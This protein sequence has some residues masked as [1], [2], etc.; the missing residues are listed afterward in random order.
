[1]NTPRRPFPAFPLRLSHL[2]VLALLGGCA[3]QDFVKKE[4]EPYGDR[5][6]SMESWFS[7][8]NNGMDTQAKR[9]LEVE[10]RLAGLEKKNATLAARQEGMGLELAGAGRRLDV[11][12]ADLTALRGQVDGA[13][14]G[15]AAVGQRLDGLEARV[16][17]S[18]RRAE[19]TVAGL[20]LLEGRVGALERNRPD[21]SPADSATASAPVEAGQTAEGPARRAK[22]AAGVG[23]PHQFVERD[24]SP[25]G[26]AA[27]AEALVDRGAQ[28]AANQ[29]LDLGRAAIQFLSLALLP[30]PGG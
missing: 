15:L 29:P 1:M 3:T 11:L 6:R 21:V 13:G 14:T 10:T 28:A 2:L 22:H 4:V 9:I 16:A 7:A 5:L 26:G 18:G 20:A 17:A 25:T 8:I 27:G 24:G 19:G 23:R 12:A 30:R